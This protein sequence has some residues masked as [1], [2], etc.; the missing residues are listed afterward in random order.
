MTF[1]LTDVLESL[2]FDFAAK[3]LFFFASCNIRV[4]L[5]LFYYRLA[6]PK[7]RWYHYTLHASMAFVIG[8]FLAG[9]FTTVFN[10]T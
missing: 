7:V 4:A 8:L 2:Q 10:C 1:S 3:I 5:L 9:L 6:D